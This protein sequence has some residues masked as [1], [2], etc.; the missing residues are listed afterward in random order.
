[1]EANSTDLI[2]DNRVFAWLAVMTVVILLVPLVGEWPWNVSD[3][4]VMGALIFGTSSL[5][6]LVARKVRRKNRLL[7][8]ATFLFAFLW[9]W[10][11]LAVGVVTNWGS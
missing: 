9:L 7:V 4:A 5:F 2:K 6:V 8:G 11:E 1:M 3:F 10:A